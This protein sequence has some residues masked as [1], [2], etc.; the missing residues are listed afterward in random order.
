MV[1]V[2]V[3]IELASNHTLHDAVFQIQSDQMPLCCDGTCEIRD[4]LNQRYLRLQ[5]IAVCP[6]VPNL[7]SNIRSNALQ[8]EHSRSPN[9][10][11]QCRPRQ[12]R[13]QGRHT[14]IEFISKAPFPN[15]RQRHPRPYRPRRLPVC[16]LFTTGLQGRSS[17]VIFLLPIP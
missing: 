17:F 9:S 15:E 10:Q 13:L 3:N 2:L 1:Y 4:P 5:Q 11:L 8:I 6:E 16:P 12:A 7:S 14:Q